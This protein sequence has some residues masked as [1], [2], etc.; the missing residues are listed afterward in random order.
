MTS[1]VKDRELD[2]YVMASTETG[3]DAYENKM[4]SMETYSFFCTHR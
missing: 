4:V 3:N 2:V 1:M